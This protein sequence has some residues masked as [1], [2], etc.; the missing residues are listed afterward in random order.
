MTV[1]L[2]NTTLS[3]LPVCLFSCQ[4]GVPIAE[5]SSLVHR[6]LATPLPRDFAVECGFDEDE[7]KSHV[8]K[9]ADGIDRLFVRNPTYG[10]FKSKQTGLHLTI[11]RSVD[12][13]WS[14]PGLDSRYP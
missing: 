1:V 5:G 11:C 13:L 8:Y 6:N 2:R 7:L 9:G 4:V 10:L 14:T 12:S 3:S